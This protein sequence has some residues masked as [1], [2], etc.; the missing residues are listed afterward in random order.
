MLKDMGQMWWQLHTPVDSSWMAVVIVVIF[1]IIEVLL[2]GM[3]V[4]GALQLVD[5]LFSKKEEST[6]VVVQ[7]QVTHHAGSTTLMMAGK[8]PVPIHHPSHTSYC[9]LIRLS[10]GNSGW[11]Y[12]NREFLEWIPEMQNVYVKYSKGWMSGTVYIQTLQVR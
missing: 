9:L 6:G 7:K 11:F 5:F 12:T 3:M 1:V 8:V 10:D 4:A 2:A